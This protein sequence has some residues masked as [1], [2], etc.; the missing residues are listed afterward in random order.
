LIDG[1]LASMTLYLR[2]SYAFPASLLFDFGGSAADRRRSLK[3][4]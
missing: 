3:T 2:K 1:L 4:S